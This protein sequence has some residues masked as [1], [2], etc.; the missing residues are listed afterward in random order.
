MA[1]AVTATQSAEILEN[2]TRLRAALISGL[3]QSLAVSGS[4]ATLTDVVNSGNLAA[5]ITAEPD[6]LDPSS[7]L[8]AANLATSLANQLA[9]SIADAP[10]QTL[11]APNTLVSVLS[12]FIGRGAACKARTAC[13][14]HSIRAPALWRSRQRVE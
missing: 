6:E 7:R 12:N 10:D 4:E 8:A 2:R 1:A 14:A 11:D 13:R 3:S 9:S 5:Q